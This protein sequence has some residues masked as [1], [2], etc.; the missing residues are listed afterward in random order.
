MAFLFGLQSFILAS[1]VFL[2]AAGLI[3]AIPPT[4][5][6]LAALCASYLEGRDY[7]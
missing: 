3:T 6:P 1:L 4:P 5:V 2:K 7:K